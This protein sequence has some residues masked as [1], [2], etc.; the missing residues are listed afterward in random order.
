MEKCTDGTALCAAAD[1]GLW[2][3]TK[4]GLLH[5]RNGRL[6]TYTTRDGLL[7]LDVRSLCADRQGSLWVGTPLGL[8]RLVEGAFRSYGREDGLADTDI[9]PLL[10]DREGSLW[11][12]TDTGLSH[13]AATKLT[14]VDFVTDRGGVA[15][16]SSAVEDRKGDVWFATSLGLFRVHG[17][18]TS[19]FDTHE[20]LP[21]EEFRSISATADGSLYVVSG[22]HGLYRF[23]KGRSFP[24]SLNR[25]IELL[26]KDSR[27]LLALAADRTLYRV[28]GSR[29]K[30]LGALPD[31][32]WIF[33]TFVDRTDTLWLATTTG[34]VRVQGVHAVTFKSGLPPETHVLS[35]SEGSSGELWLGTDKG[36]AR[37]RDGSFRLY[38]TANGLPDDNFY[39]ALEDGEG[40]VSLGGTRGLVTVKL[41]DFAAIDSG[42]TTRLD[43]TLYDDFDGIRAVSRCN[44]QP[45]R[46]GWKALVRGRERRYGGRPSRRAQQ[47]ADTLC[48]DRTGSR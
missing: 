20:G 10:E 17:Y 35:I 15:K 27:G 21:S 32:G 11:V 9:G 19:H 22:A 45:A 13:F 44:V 34:L 8:N 30:R 23:A 28:D 3:G 14:P 12:A 29:L 33:G 39:S 47:S 2:I 25:G 40:R 1:G 46:P 16:V 6:R 4:H 18:E 42:R 7:S 41:A 26:A 24:I 43:F 5:L 48:A 31:C 37:F 38:S 36:V